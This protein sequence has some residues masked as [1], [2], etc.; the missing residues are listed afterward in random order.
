MALI[1]GGGYA[2][3]VRYGL[4]GKMNT[5]WLLP[6]TASSLLAILIGCFQQ[7]RGAARSATTSIKLYAFNS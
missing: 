3:L 5:V 4:F 1:G 6:D 7:R 2:G